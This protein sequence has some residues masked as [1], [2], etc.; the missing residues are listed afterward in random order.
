MGNS[1]QAAGDL[2][3]AAGAFK[4]ATVLGSSSARF[5]LLFHEAARAGA[6]HTPEG[7]QKCVNLLSDLS[8]DGLAMMEKQA[9]SA[10]QVE[11]AKW[12][13]K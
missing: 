6:S 10:L 9:R 3:A 12:K 11:C 2:A 5:A 7:A 1:A 8:E 4:K 13:R